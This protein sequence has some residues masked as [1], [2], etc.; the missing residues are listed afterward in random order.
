MQITP[1]FSGERLDLES[2]RVHALR[3]GDRDEDVKQAIAT[4]LVALAKAGER[5]PDILCEQVLRD[6]RRARV[7]PPQL[8]GLHRCRG[9]TMAD[10]HACKP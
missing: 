3:T 9:R 2:R 10:A 8:G 4:K 5:N 7:R 6:I 1:F